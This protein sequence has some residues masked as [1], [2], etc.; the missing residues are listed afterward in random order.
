VEDTKRDERT[1]DRR[2]FLR[3][4][5]LAG[6]GLCSAGLDP[7]P[8]SATPRTALAARP[9]RMQARV[10]ILVL[11]GTGFVG[12]HLVRSALARG[13]EV[14]LFNRGRTNPDLFADLELLRG[15]RYP[16]RDEGLGALEGERTWDAIVD[17][18]QAEPG[19]VDR[20]ARM[21]AG[22]AGRYVYVS[23]IA[24]YGRFVEIGMT[25]EAPAIEATEH[26][27]SFDADLGYPVRKRASELAVERAFG[28]RGTVLRATSIGGP[29]EAPVAEGEPAG[30]WIYRFRLGEP[31]LA[32]DDPTA[33]FQLVD[34][35][36]LADFAVR[37]IERQH[38]GTYNL[39]GP[40][41]PLPFADFMQAQ[42]RAAGGHSRVVWVDPAWLLEQGVRPWVDVPS[43]I[44]A[45]DPEPGFY[46][47][48][49]RKAVAAGLRFRPVAETIRDGFE[50]MPGL[51]RFAPPSDGMDRERELELIRAWERRSGARRS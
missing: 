38:A 1:I 26:I 23:S 36:D 48:S 43:W 35:R 51:D 47:L 7:G 15:N 4:A 49:N 39:V 46:R 41:E 8:T 18:W 5:G 12:P 31:V 30:Y 27:G 2:T 21:L 25:E 33:V 44:P 20:T 13:H 19:C 6:A 37:G 17:T 11:G 10:R 24:A 29:S 42:Q 16:D 14:T 40:A 3:A 32:P 9:G 45:D 22:R 34:V 50:S 28:E